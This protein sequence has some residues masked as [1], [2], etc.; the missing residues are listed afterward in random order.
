M[1]EKTFWIVLFVVLG[2]CVAVTLAHFAYAVYAYQHSS[3]IF[4][5]GK[6]LWG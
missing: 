4:F 1:K 5:I 3:I 2:L 6:E